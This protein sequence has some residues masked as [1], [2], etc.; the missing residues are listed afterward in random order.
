M[1]ASEPRYTKA[2]TARLGQ[3]RYRK[4]VQPLV[5]AAHQGEFVAIDIESGAYELDKDDFAATEKLLARQ[6]DAQIWLMR[7]GHPA[8]R[9][10]GGSRLAA[11]HSKD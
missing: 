6:P 7:V 5:E 11:K 2:E 4:D 1:H 9:C 3:E 10:M 8:T